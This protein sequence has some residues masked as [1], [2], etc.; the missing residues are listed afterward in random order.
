MIESEWRAILRL[1]GP[2]ALAQVGQMLMGIVDIA[3]VGRLGAGA[4]AAAAA[5]HGVAILVSLF[6]MGIA[7]GLDPIVSQRLGAKDQ[8]GAWRA[9]SDSLRL[10]LFC[11]APALLLVAV[12]ETI[13]LRPNIG[14]QMFPAWLPMDPAVAE[15]A[16]GYTWA[17][18]PGVIPFMLFGAYRAWFYAHHLTKV[19]IGVTI[20]GNVANA[21]L[22]YVF[23]F[24]DEG[25]VRIGLPPLGIPAGGV[26][27][28][29]ATTSAVSIL[30]IAYL[31]PIALRHRRDTIRATAAT[32]AT[33]AP[34]PTSIT[35]S[36]SAGIRRILRLGVPIGTLIA[37]EAGIFVLVSW[38]SGAFGPTIQA[39]QEVALKIA[40]FTFMVTVGIGAAASVRVGRAIGAGTTEAARRSGFTA[41]WMSVTWMA[42]CGLVLVAFPRQL[43]GVFTNDENVI[44]AA[45]P[46]LRIAALFQVFDGTQSAISGALRG[47]GD[48]RI[49]ML[50]NLVAY[51][52]VGLPISHLIAFRFGM[53]AAG[54]WVGLTA[55]LV[56]VAVLLTWRFH[57][58]TRRPVA[59]IA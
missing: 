35:E 6:F 42:F 28:S 21:I 50:A 40:S 10:T 37:L 29:G 45:I 7:M 33:G 48:T 34:R 31:A 51:W 38:M 1:A 22:D 4:I 23:V 8:D 19:M 15:D 46:L 14:G 56:V 41:L 26:V 5:G 25:L 47:A 3:I 12:I 32:A 30:S 13:T 27:A 9:F 39:A 16:I 54:L 52:V 11:V 24:G 2:I 43:A 49:P 18:A 57:L 44:A 36:R 58:L 53:G 55:G 59:R 17:R 20:V